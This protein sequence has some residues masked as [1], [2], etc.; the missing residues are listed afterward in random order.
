MWRWSCTLRTATATATVTNAVAAAATARPSLPAAAA[1]PSCW[2]RSSASPSLPL[3]HA[4]AHST[5]AAAAKRRLSPST[6]TRQ[7]AIAHKRT[8]LE[9]PA[10]TAAA[11]ASLHSAAAAAANAHAQTPAATAPWT[12]PPSDINMST[13]PIS[14]VRLQSS[15]SPAPFGPTMSARTHLAN[16]V[17]TRLLSLCCSFVTVSLILCCS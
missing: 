11:T 10:A 5:I 12:L 1:V 6:A 13:A 8:R 7:F 15:Q 2:M 17:R 9:P 14:Q 16:S 4:A 3:T